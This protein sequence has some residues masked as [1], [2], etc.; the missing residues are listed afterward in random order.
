MSRVDEA[1]AKKLTPEE[2]EHFRELIAEANRNE[3]EIEEYKARA[4]A[5]AEAMGDNWKHFVVL[6]QQIHK[7]M[8]EYKVG[9]YLSAFP[10]SA[11][12][13]N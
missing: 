1:M 8:Q 10:R 9:L 6:I 4:L 2:L 13:R 3:A 7:E 5:V 11:K 12:G